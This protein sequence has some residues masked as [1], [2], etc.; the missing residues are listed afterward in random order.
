MQL[1]LDNIVAT[2]IAGVLFLVLVA[3]NQRSR[4]AAVETSNYYALKQQELTFVE[5]LKRDMQNVTDLQSVKE[6]PMTLEFRFKARTDPADTTRQDVAYRRVYKGVRD[7]LPLYQ[8]Q[9]IVA[10]QPDG[11]SMSTIV[12]WE[13]V[14]Q[15]ED[16]GSC[17]AASCRQIYVRFEAINPFQQG[18]TVDRSRWEATFRP[19]QLQQVTTI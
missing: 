6:D 2:M 7:G 13:I 11:G 4:M 19:T 10:G 18:E 12:K 16:G 1:I 9:R 14:G 8:V 15:S 3:V 5:T 17:V